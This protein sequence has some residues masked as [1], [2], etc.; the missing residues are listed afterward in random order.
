[1]P[2]IPNG[3]T[4]LVTFVFSGISV[5]RGA[6]CTI[7]FISNL[8]PIGQDDAD[9]FATRADNLVIGL[10]AAGIACSHVEVKAGPNSTGGTWEAPAGEPGGAGNNPAPPNVA[11]LIRKVTALGGRRGR[12]RMFWPCIEESNIDHAGRIPTLDRAAKQAVVDSF[13]EDVETFGR[14]L[15]LLHDTAAVPPTPITSL[16]VDERVATQRD[17]LR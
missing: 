6:V 13:F 11:T 8:V 9:F 17:R 10:C 14:Q 1:M 15:V 7:G 2:V 4:G 3:N 12:G 16:V 5:P